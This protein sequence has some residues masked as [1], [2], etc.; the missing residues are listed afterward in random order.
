MSQ[1]LEVLDRAAPSLASSGVFP[2]LGAGGKTSILQAAARKLV[3]P[4]SAPNAALLRLAKAA[5]LEVG[6]TQGHL[7]ATLNLEA[8]DETVAKQMVLVGQGLMAL[9][10]LQKDNPGSVKLAE[11]LSLKQDG[12]E[13]VASVTASDADVVELMKADAAKK[14]QKKAKAEED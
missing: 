7:R 2:K 5:R 14:A 6:V 12:A 4:E 11:G 8:A 9:I 13:L 1:A 3:L 10:K